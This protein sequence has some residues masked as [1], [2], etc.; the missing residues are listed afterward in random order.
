LGNRKSSRAAE[1]VEAVGAVAA[2]AVVVGRVPEGDFRRRGEPRVRPAPKLDQAAAVDRKLLLG[3]PAG[4]LQHGP[5]AHK[6]QHGLL[7]VA[8]PPKALEPRDSAPRPAPR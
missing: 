1:E 7:G 3:R 8:P 5:A 2:E 4:K 6:P